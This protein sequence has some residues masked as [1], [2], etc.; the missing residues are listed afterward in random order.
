MKKNHKRLRWRDLPLAV[1]VLC[2]VGLVAIIL[3]CTNVLMYWQVNKTMQRL[4]SV[5]VSNVNLT[6]LEESLE[7]VQSSMYSSLKIIRPV[8]R[9]CRTLYNIWR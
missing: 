5:Y 3:F 6:E 7:S 8:I 4:D 9:L 2:Q 1:K